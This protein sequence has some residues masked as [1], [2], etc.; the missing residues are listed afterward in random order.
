MAISGNEPDI[1]LITEVLPKIHLQTIASG[2]A[3]GGHGRAFAQPSLIL[4]PP[5]R[6]C[7]Y[8]ICS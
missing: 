7:F 8:L 6:Y 3:R 2:V 4:A 5:S 1:M